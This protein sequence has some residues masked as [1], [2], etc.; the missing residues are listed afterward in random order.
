MGKGSVV[1]VVVVVVLCVPDQKRGGLYTRLPI[2][3]P[4]LYVEWQHSWV[5]GEPCIARY[6][7][8][9]TGGGAINEG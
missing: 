4:K 1:V 7:F 8:Q 2:P 6:G 9:N 3:I 5:G